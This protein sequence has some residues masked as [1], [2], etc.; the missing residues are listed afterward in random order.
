MN[1]SSK[2]LKEDEK[3]ETLL[4]IR[5]LTKYFD[6]K[7]ILDGVNL[8]LKRKER[9]SVLGPGGS[10]KTTLLKIIIGLLQPDFGEIEIMGEN[11]SNLTGRTRQNLLRRVAM[12]FQLGGLFDFLNVRENIIFAMENMTDLSPSDMDERVVELLNAV[13]LPHAASKLPSELSGGM[14]RRV[15]IVRAMATSP[16]LGLFDEP[17]AGLDPVTSTVVIDMIHQ[18]AKQINSACLCVTSS[19]EVAF[20]FSQQVAILKDG[21]IIGQGT[22]AELRNL[23]D[24]WLDHFLS[25]RQFQPTEA[26][27]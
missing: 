14:R 9:L 5:N 25:V 17:T 6:N 20:T 8:T 23:G 26:N 27:L 11:L 2:H 22:W 16:E 21:K 15:G 1:D 19:V 12:A 3:Q 18:I 10:G 13:K 24:P 4:E 7:I